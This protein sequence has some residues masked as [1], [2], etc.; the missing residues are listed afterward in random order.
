M[1]DIKKLVIQ[2]VAVWTNTIERMFV[3]GAWQNKTDALGNKVFGTWIRARTQDL[4]KKQVI[5]H[6]EHGLSAERIQALLKTYPTLNYEANVDYVYRSHNDFVDKDTGEVKF[7]Y[8]V[9]APPETEVA[10]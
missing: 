3:N 2:L 8:F 10:G 6:K 9:F 5:A 4:S 1:A 7:R